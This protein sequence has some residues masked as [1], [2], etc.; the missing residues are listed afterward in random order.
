MK[1]R[2]PGKVDGF[3]ISAGS[4]A[5]TAEP[6][7]NESRAKPRI[8]VPPTLR[9]NANQSQSPLDGA[10]SARACVLGAAEAAFLAR[11][12]PEQRATVLGDDPDRVAA[13]EAWE[14]EHRPQ[15]VAAAPAADR[16]Q[17]A[18]R[19]R[20]DR[21]KPRTPAPTPLAESWTI[22]A[23]GVAPDPAAAPP[24]EPLVLAELATDPDEPA[25]RRRRG[26]LGTGRDRGVRRTRHEAAAREADA[27]HARRW[28][29]QCEDDYA[30]AATP[31]LTML[32]VL[33]PRLVW[34]M[35][36][37]TMADRTGDAGRSWLR[38][39]RSRFSGAPLA[40]IGTAAF[41]PDA[42]G[43]SRYDW[44]DDCARATVVLGLALLMMGT[45]TRRK[46]VWAL[47]VRGVVRQALCVLIAVR[48][49]RPWSTEWLAGVRGEQLHQLGPLRRLERV[50]LLYR[51]Q[52]P[53]Q[54]KSVEGFECYPDRKGVLRTSN[55]YWLGWRD[56][57]PRE[58]L[59]A[60]HNYG[61][62]LCDALIRRAPRTAAELRYALRHG[63]ARAPD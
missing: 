11:L 48:P 2:R 20:A 33:I 35:A 42:E 40:R 61:W 7:S 3:E 13:W 50:G 22:P 56:A 57:H 6:T 58:D 38:W 9:E 19:W 46:G 25:P 12:P 18:D 52:L 4:A 8:D 53:A 17:A 63:R 49:D 37:S 41:C 44:H 51:Q 31:R 21:D 36:W 15:G 45:M 32:R 43:R 29:R 26:R 59:A 23:Q 55:R 54:A 39:A 5:P 34:I 10:T 27:A 1:S 14:A 47:C 60:L 62:E 24:D 28:Q 30:A 16:Q